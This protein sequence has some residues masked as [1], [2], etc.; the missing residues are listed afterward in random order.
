VATVCRILGISAA[1]ATAV[2]PSAAWVL[3]AIPLGAAALAALAVQW[4]SYPRPPSRLAR[5]AGAARDAWIGRAA[6]LWNVV[7]GMRPARRTRG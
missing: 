3:Y 5:A 2:R 7:F 1:N 6:S 4:Q